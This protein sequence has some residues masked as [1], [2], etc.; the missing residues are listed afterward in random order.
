MYCVFDLLHL[1]G[2]SLVDRP[3]QERRARLTGRYVT[4]IAHMPG[5]RRSGSIGSF[6]VRRFPTPSRRSPTTQNRKTRLQRIM[7]CAEVFWWGKTLE[8]YAEQLLEQFFR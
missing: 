8:Q 3:L 4:Q 5:R 2:Q 7:V 6:R 1:G